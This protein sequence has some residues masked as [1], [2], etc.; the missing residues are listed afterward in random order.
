MSLLDFSPRI[1]LGTFSILLVHVDHLK[2]YTGES[3]PDAWQE[4]S[5]DNTTQMSHD[6]TTQM[7]QNNMT[8]MSEPMAMNQNQ[9]PTA[10]PDNDG[11]HRSPPRTRCGRHVR[12]PQ[13][14]SP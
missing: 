14:Y 8:Q 10:A 3:V 7:S 11:T 6:N 4:I 9:V 5:S 13:I 12:R 2:P 1:P